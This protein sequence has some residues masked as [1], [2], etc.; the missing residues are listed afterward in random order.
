MVKL[1]KT[2]SILLSGTAILMC[3]GVT[4]HA[5]E[6]TQ[7]EALST[8]TQASESETKE[9][10]RI[11][12]NIVVTA[13]K[14]EQSLNDVPMSITV[15]S[16]T[17]MFERGVT[18]V[19]SLVKFTPG[20]SYVESGAGVPVFSLR[21]VGFYDTAFGSRPTVSVYQDEISLPFS[22]MSKG[23]S[24]DLERVEILKGP[25]G[26]LFGQNSTGGAINYV[27][28]KPTGDSSGQIAASFSSF[29]T[30]DTSGH[31]NVPLAD[32]LNAR[33]SA[34][35]LVGEGWQ[36]SI[37]RSDTL[38]AKSFYQ[39]RVQFDW[40]ASDRLSLLFNINGFVDNSETQAAQRIDTIFSVPAFADQIPIVVN[41]PAFPEDNRAADWDEGR[42]LKK[43]NNFWQASVRADF[44]LTEYLSLTSLTAYSSM[45]IGQLVDQDG[46]FVTA[47]L[48]NVTGDL[49]SFSQEL[50]LAG[51]ADRLNYVFGANYSHDKSSEKDFFQFPY[52]TSSFG[53]IP[54][55]RA[56]ASELISQQTF[57]TLAV[58]GN[59]EYELTDQL[60]AHAGIRYTRAELDSSGCTTVGNQTSADTFGVLVN[61]IRGRAG[62]PPLSVNVDDCV[63]LDATLTP[64]VQT[65][66]LDEDNRS[67]RAGL[68]WAPMDDML[69]YANISKGYKAGSSPTIP[70]IEQSELSPVTQESVLAYEAGLKASLIDNV[71]EVSGAVFL[72]DYEDKQ[73]Q[74]RV[75]TILGVLPGLVNV[76]E[77]E[78][79]GAEF[80]VNAFPLE[81]LRL[82]LAGTYIE[83]EVTA[84]FTNFSILGLPANF[85]GNEFPY[86][87]EF[88]LVFD[89]E[90]VTPLTPTIDGFIG[91]N[92]NYRSSTTS[93]FGDD[94][95]LNIDAYTVV[96]M[97]LGLEA[98]DGGWRAG[99]FVR[100]LTDEYYWNNVARTSDIIRRY[101]GE[102]RSFGISLSRSF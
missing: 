62:L 77:S 54:G 59:L 93:G 11:L 95:R 97:R 37:T 53:T 86:T 14:R 55:L 39:G 61:F 21:G 81:G 71:L 51:S 65:D 15:M 33:F 91:L 34:R 28:A 24:F 50:R 10:S 23:A 45:D 96:D 8:T 80:Q 22:I 102:P 19:E 92:A 76:P 64:G 75:I 78:I 72:Y 88:Q 46:T 5:Q 94:P 57:D 9:T 63:S 83:S 85:K 18:D 87:P 35:A 17:D 4:A 68:D 74:G 49:T 60:R 100:N 67:W 56:D 12:D 84:D 47:S 98:A 29:N 89:S 44:E 30:L 70:A 38:G 52:T 40:E 26:T 1:F 3:A 20:L 90:Y 73:L 99:L 42:A 16:G 79:R 13:Q 41:Y 31:V 43:D 58:F 69:L 32:T 82:T 66:K 36:E 48:T 6:T 101:T 2:R 27:A 7:D 25:Q